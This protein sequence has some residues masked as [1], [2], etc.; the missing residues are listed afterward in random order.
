MKPFVGIFLS[1]VLTNFFASSVYDISI[2]TIEGSTRVLQEFQGKKILVTILPVTQTAEDTAFLQRL[3]SLAMTNSG[4][5]VV[6]AVPSYEDGF[7]DSLA[8]VLQP[9]YR[10]FLDTTLVLTQG[11]YTHQSSDSLQN[12]LFNWLTHVSGNTHFEQEVGGPGEMYFINEQGELY[13]VIGPE[14]KFSNTVLG[15]MFH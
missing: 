9:F 14:A 7:T 6:I 4:Q 1:V 3:D 2:T 11:T 10:S 13:G 15:N 5:L 12:P 8:T